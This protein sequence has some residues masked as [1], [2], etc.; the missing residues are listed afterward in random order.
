MLPNGYAAEHPVSDLVFSRILLV[1]H[2]LDPLVYFER[3]VRA[4]GDIGI[5][6]PR[7]F[8]V[9]RFELP[10]AGKLFYQRR[11]LLLV[12]R[13]AAGEQTQAQCGQYDIDSLSHNLHAFILQPTSVFGLYRA[14]DDGELLGDL[15]AAHR[16]PRAETAASG[17]RP[18]RYSGHAR[19]GA[20]QP[21]FPGH[22]GRLRRNTELGPVSL[23]DL[24]A[25]IG[26][27]RRSLAEVLVERKLLLYA[28]F[29]FQAGCA[30]D[31]HEQL[32]GVDR[33]RTHLLAVIA[34]LHGGQGLFG[35]V[36]VGV[37]VVHREASI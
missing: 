4:E 7:S 25:E 9:P 17:N 16:C 33:S 11:H 5:E 8:A 31:L 19:L 37:D 21:Q 3:T 24:D 18:D 2:L 1:A 34:Q 6:I 13:S 23:R 32:V 26:Q 29:R 30:L 35:A 14:G 10:F 28:D 15:H 12:R 27:V 36:E 20:V 22:E